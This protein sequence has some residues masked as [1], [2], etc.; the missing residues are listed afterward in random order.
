MKEVK[1]LIHQRIIILGGAGFIGSHVCNTLAGKA[2]SVSSVDIIKSDNID[3]KVTQFIGNIADTTFISSIIHGADVVICLSSHSLPGSANVDLSS[4]IK[5]HV[6]TI[7]KIAELCSSLGVKKFLF[8]SSGG[9]VYGDRKNMETIDENSITLPINAYGISKLSIE[10][11]LRLLSRNHEMS[12]T[13]LRISN[14][15]GEGQRNNKKQGFIASSIEK[16]KTNETIE[17]WGNGDTIRDYIYIDDLANAFLKAIEY[18]GDIT[19]INVGSGIGLSLNQVLDNIRELL[20][21]DF[22]IK[23]LQERNIDVSNNI[24]NINIAEEE[25]RWRPQTSFQQGLYKTLCWWKLNK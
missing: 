22:S 10:H 5:G 20:D 6:Y 17:I 4:E 24:L 23:Y 18:Y 21:K 3:R 2:K 7:V 16:I 25:L 1:P 15:Y 11:Y 12:I 13:S 8:A 9:T 19:E 14:P